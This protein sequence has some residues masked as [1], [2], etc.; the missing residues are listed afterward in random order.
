MEAVPELS[1]WP[2]ALFPILLAGPEQ[3]VHGRWPLDLSDDKDDM[4]GVGALNARLSAG[5]ALHH[6]NGGGS[7][8]SDGY[9]Y[10]TLYASST[11]NGAY[12]SE[13]W[14]ARVPRGTTLRV[15]AVL[16]AKGACTQGGDENSCSA[17]DWVYFK[18]WGC[19]G[20]PC[21]YV[22]GYSAN[23]NSNY[24][25]FGYTNQDV[26]DHDISIALQM[27]DWSPLTSTT[28]GIAWSRYD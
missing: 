15:A 1:Y 18:L 17:E 5:I 8:H 7:A 12:Y 28:F 25:Y 3:N 24:Q 20:W 22:M 11:P 26:V 6:R 14:N 23:F 19:I 16:F 21:Q 2:E 27:W 10:G 4:D 13:I 9:D